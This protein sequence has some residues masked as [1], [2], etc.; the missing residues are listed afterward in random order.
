MIV[1]VTPNPAMDRTVVI[2][3][4]TLGTINRAVTERTDIGGKGINVARH[5]ARLGCDVVATGFLGA[6]DMYDVVQ[7]LAA[8]GVRTDF[9]RIAG[10]TRVNLKILDPATGQETEINESGPP[11]GPDRVEAL[12]DKLSAVAPHSRVMVFSG[13][14]PPGA[15]ADLYARGVA[16]AAGAGIKTILDAAGAALRYGIAAKPDLI[17]PNRAEAEE[18]LG[19]S[20][21][22]DADLAAGARR[23]VEY[24]ARTAVISLGPAGAVWASAEGVWRARAP[25]ITARNSVGSGDAMVAGLAWALIR[26]LAAPDA[27]R[28]ATALGSA[29]AASDAPLPAPG[30]LEALLPDV[31][32]ESEA[33]GKTPYDAARTGP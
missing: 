13:S 18:L 23:L 32:V 5:L 19:V 3:G 6:R 20:L 28:L 15:P 17:K 21:D 9:V 1:T 31:L 22:S 11:V 2:R 4:F 14:L 26:S 12:L 29:T 33:F 30:R 25:Q 8:Q 27:L 24:G 7:T 16:L 10:D